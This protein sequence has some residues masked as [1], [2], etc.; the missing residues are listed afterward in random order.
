[1]IEIAPATGESQTKKDQ[2]MTNII[3]ARRVLR[4][5]FPERPRVWG[6]GIQRRNP[7]REAEISKF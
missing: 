6:G 7:P 5:F 1:V 3:G 4:A 2:M